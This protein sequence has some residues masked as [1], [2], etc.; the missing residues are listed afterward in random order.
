MINNKQNFRYWLA[1]NLGML[2]E[3]LLH[4]QRL[5]LWCA[6]GRFDIIG[7]YFFQEGKC[8]VIVFLPVL[9]RHVVFLLGEYFSSKTIPQI[10]ILQINLWHSWVPSIIWPVLSANTSYLGYLKTRVF[11]EPLRALAEVSDACHEFSWD[12][13]CVDNFTIRPREC[14]DKNC[15]HVEDITFRSWLFFNVFFF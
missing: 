10:T 2:H 14:R 8:T 1:L 7:P 15:H 11:I 9:R 12:C 4:S 6:L 3:R 5:S 13:D